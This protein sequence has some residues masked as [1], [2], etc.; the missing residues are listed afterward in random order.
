[1]R[2]HSPGRDVVVLIRPSILSWC[3]GPVMRAKPLKKNWPGGRPVIAQLTASR[4]A[5]VVVVPVM[6]CP[7]LPSTGTKMQA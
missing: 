1:M 5:P 6:I 7:P 4:L 3:Q 2:T